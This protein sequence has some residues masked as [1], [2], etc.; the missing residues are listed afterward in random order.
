MRLKTLKITDL[1]QQSP[2][3]LA[4]ETGFSIDRAVGE[5]E[6]EGEWETGGGAQASLAHGPVSNR[7]QMGTSPQTRVGDP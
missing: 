1:D 6:E 7:P 3:F 5:G 4:P 2:N